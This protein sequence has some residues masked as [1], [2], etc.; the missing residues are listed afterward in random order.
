MAGACGKKDALPGTAGRRA[1]GGQS[2]QAQPEEGPHSSFLLGKM[3]WRGVR[4]E[5]EGRHSLLPGD[6]GCQKTG[7]ALA[8][9]AV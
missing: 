2:P 8:Q 5:G 7:L 4:R 1:A 9:P 3:R 6:S